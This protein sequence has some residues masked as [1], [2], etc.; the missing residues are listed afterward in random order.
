[1]T[2]LPW[3]PSAAGSGGNAHNELY[4]YDAFVSYGTSRGIVL[5]SEA[6]TV[7]NWD[8]YEVMRG[9]FLYIFLFFP[10]GTARVAV[11]VRDL[12]NK[13]KATH[14]KKEKG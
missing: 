5:I 12:R 9:L 3:I 1:M 10:A 4:D 7:S 6:G 11:V 14:K 8:G 2:I 13:T